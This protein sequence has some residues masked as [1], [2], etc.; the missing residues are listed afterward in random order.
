MQIKYMQALLAKI[1]I[2]K[3]KSNKKMQKKNKIK[4]KIKIKIK[5]NILS[6]YKHQLWLKQDRDKKVGGNLR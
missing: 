1:L 3:Q 2:N 6:L 4:M 5:S